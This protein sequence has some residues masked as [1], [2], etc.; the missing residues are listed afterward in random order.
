MVEDNKRERLNDVRVMF[1][2]AKTTLHVIGVKDDIDKRVTNAEIPDA[3]KD[4]GR[5]NAI[6]AFQVTAF[7]S[8]RHHVNRTSILGWSKPSIEDCPRRLWRME[9]NV[10]WSQKNRAAVPSG[11]ARK[12]EGKVVLKLLQHVL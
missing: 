7:V 5:N 8:A 11:P 10:L 9:V 3:L 12:W 4:L 2:L 1:Q 6:Q